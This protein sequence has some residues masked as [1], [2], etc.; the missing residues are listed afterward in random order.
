MNAK[1]MLGLIA[2]AA[3]GFVGGCILTKKKLEIDI[4]KELD[5]KYDKMYQQQLHELEEY[6]GIKDEYQN[7]EDKETE[8]ED[9]NADYRELVRERREAAD[10]NSTKYNKT[11]ESTKKVKR[12]DDGSIDLHYVSEEEEEAIAELEATANLKIDW[13]EYEE[14]ER[15]LELL[16]EHLAD[17]DRAPFVVHPDDLGDVHGYDNEMVTFYMYNEVY[18]LDNGEIMDNPIGSLGKCIEPWEDNDEK[19]IFIANPAETILYE[20]EK[21]WDAYRL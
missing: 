13:E 4:R 2:S 20:V 12:L 18:E 8:K 17:K 7:R 21:K 3:V 14:Y 11:Y 10:A 5:E 9:S 1:I 15:D 19:F 16:H 6:F